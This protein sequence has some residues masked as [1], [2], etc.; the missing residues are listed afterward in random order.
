VHGS[1]SQ[2]KK[3]ARTLM[4]RIESDEFRSSRPDR[5]NQRVKTAAESQW[6]SRRVRMNSIEF[7]TPATHAVRLREVRTA[8]SPPCRDVWSLW[9]PKRLAA[10]P[11]VSCSL[12][13]REAADRRR[14][15]AGEID[16]S[17]DMAA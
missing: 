8:P 17:F 13:C 14:P 1:C 5:V 12:A 9:R 2:W 6:R 7:S 4:T 11:C 10:V 3:Q 15:F 16:E